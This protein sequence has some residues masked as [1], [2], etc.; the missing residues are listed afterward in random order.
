[1]R[2]SQWDIHTVQYTSVPQPTLKTKERKKNRIEMEQRSVSASK[3]RIRSTVEML[4]VSNKFG[5]TQPWKASDPSEYITKL[6]HGQYW[7]SSR[8][9]PASNNHGSARQYG[10]I[11][12]GFHLDRIV[13]M[14]TCPEKRFCGRPAR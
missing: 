4:S 2:D 7:L 1:M 13:G 14:A 12:T 10:I 6:S 11:V 9:G 8:A 3:K 5:A